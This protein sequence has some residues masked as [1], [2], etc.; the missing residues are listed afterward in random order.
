MVG[1]PANRRVYG[2][3]LGKVVFSGTPAE[4]LGDRDRLRELFL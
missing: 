3:K 2:L 4:P 1:G